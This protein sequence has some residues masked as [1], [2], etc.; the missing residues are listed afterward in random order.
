VHC[1]AENGSTKRIDIIIISK[2]TKKGY[3]LDPTVRFESAKD[4]PSDVN[5]EKKAHYEP[6]IGY[7]KS[8]YDLDSIEV[9]G[10]MVGAR[11]TITDFFVRFLRDFKIYSKSL[12]NEIVLVALKGAVQILHNHLYNLNTM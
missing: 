1:L 7:F 10:L 11:G 9:I 12:V 2:L 6:T 5:M 8:K 4:Q 3:I